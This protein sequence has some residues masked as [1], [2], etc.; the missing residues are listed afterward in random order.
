MAPRCTGE[1]SIRLMTPE[2]MSSMKFMPLQ[3]AENSAVITT[4]PGV[5]KVM[6]EAPPKP[7]ILTTSWFEWGLDVTTSWFEWGLDVLIRG[8]ASY[9]SEA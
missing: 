5:R 6:Y 4:T 8:L 9:V 7:G 1:T 3:P 2:S